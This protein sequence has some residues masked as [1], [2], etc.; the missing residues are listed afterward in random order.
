MF[1]QRQSQIF[2]SF[3]Y[4]QV[5]TAKELSN[6][7]SISTK[8]IR[9][10]IKKINC[11]IMEYG[12]EIK[13][14]PGKGF[15]IEPATTNENMIKINSDLTR[16]TPLESSKD[17]SY[18]IISRLLMNNQYIKVDQFAKDFYVD[19]TSISKDLNYVRSCLHEF[20]L[21]LNHK[22]HHGIRIDGSEF[23]K[24]RAI[25]EY[26]FF[27]G[28]TLYNQYRS[29]IKII[30][31][32]IRNILEIDGIS[33]QEVSFNSLLYHLIILD[34]RI[35]TNK[36]IDIDYDILEK[37]N[38]SYEM[39]V[40]ED[41]LKVMK[42]NR[43]DHPI[44]CAYVAMHI[45]SKKTN[46][47]SE[48]ESCINNK[49]NPVIKQQVEDMIH[50]IDL[51]FGT[52]LKEDSYLV[53]SL[54]L[55]YNQMIDRMSFGLLQRNQILE[56]IKGKYTYSYLIAYEMLYHIGIKNNIVF[57]DNEASFIALHV[58]YS[59]ERS[60]TYV[61]RVLLINDLN[62]T[63]AELIQLLLLK[64]LGS[65]IQ[66]VDV[67]NSNDY[68]NY[69]LDDID[70]IVATTPIKSDEKEVF[71]LSPIP[72]AEEYERLIKLI[73]PSQK[74]DDILISEMSTRNLE[75]FFKDTVNYYGK[76][77]KEY[78]LN[79]VIVSNNWLIKPVITETKSEIQY[80]ELNEERI[81]KSKLVHGVMYVK[82]AKGRS[83]RTL[84]IVQKIIK[85]GS[86]N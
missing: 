27:S 8:T 46:T 26:G 59:F 52:H 45:I 1:T 36:I 55:H 74:D 77:D 86:V 13:S 64:K 5:Q 37:V 25:V 11:E 48:I 14:I 15:M 43:S 60:T 22:P 63:N 28:K 78:S 34:K 67:I 44:E 17:R 85:D 38:L 51:T 72:N 75:V 84:R 24:R 41:I 10:E 20:N 23:D 6:K 61:K 9:N 49:L 19:R 40:A 2:K 4:K 62:A 21:T 83:R 66:I 58:E 35:K 56:D 3:E 80:L 70:L 12:I 82:L 42:Y 69:K 53:K 47:T 18:A 31:P 54:G 30:E 7:L 81:Y 76:K 57:N 73:K 68:H 33:M 65:S 32:L 29:E 50:H 71:I 39:L 16:N 79:P